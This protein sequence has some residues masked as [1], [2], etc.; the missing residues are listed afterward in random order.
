ME[1]KKKRDL[2]GQVA[3]GPQGGMAQWLRSTALGPLHAINDDVP[4]RAVVPNHW[5]MG[6]LVPG[7]IQKN[8]YYFFY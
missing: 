5:S 7:R 4:S 6:H 2:C 1:V 8:E 3:K